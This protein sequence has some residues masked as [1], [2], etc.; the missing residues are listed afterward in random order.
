MR[1]TFG[2]GKASYLS[3]GSKADQAFILGK[4]R[5]PYIPLTVTFYI[6]DPDSGKII[7]HLTCYLLI[8]AVNN[9]KSVIGTDIKISVVKAC[10][11]NDLILDTSRMSIIKEIV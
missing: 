8:V 1:H 9:I 3:V 6:T 5:K 7:R 10:R 4:S 2:S 11:I